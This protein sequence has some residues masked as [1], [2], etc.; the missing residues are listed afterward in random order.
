MN[1]RTIAIG[2]GVLILIVGLTYLLISI[3]DKGQISGGPCSYKIVKYPAEV[4]RIDT[5]SD[6]ELALS[7]SIESGEFIDT[8][9]S[10]H[11][12]QRYFE[13]T[14]VEH[15]NLSLET[16]LTYEQHEII[17]GSCNPS[18]GKLVLQEFNE[19]TDE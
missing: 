3:N 4:V 13:F 17:E 12:T 7:L 5:V 18:I 1:Q 15:L 19:K 8:L 11:I 16:V 9:N 6:H 10:Y 14:E 2:V